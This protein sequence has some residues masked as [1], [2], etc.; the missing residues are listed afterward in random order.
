ME[1]YVKIVAVVWILF[2]ICIVRFA[3]SMY[4]SLIPAVLV[5]GIWD[6]GF[7]SYNPINFH[8]TSFEYNY[9]LI[10]A[11]MTTISVLVILYEIV[12]TET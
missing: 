3:I 5:T 10:V 12:Q 9:L 8:T 7:H 2:V 6:Y 11:A 4:N 1:F